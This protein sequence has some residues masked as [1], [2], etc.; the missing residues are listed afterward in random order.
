MLLLVRMVIC[1]LVA[2][3]TAHPTCF[4]RKAQAYANKNQLGF[5]YYQMSQRRKKE[6]FLWQMRFLT[7]SAQTIF[8]LTSK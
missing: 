8:L 4:K 1:L 6:D 2:V 3:V 5:L 7:S